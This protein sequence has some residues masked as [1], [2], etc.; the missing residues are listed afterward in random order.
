MAEPNP[1]DCMSGP[2]SEADV[3]AAANVERDLPTFQ[4]NVL[5]KYFRRANFSAEDVAEIDYQR[6]VRFPGVG[7][8]GIQNIRTWLHTFA[9]D[10]SNAPAPGDDS[11]RHERDP[12][13]KAQRIE[14]AIALLRKQ[15]FVVRPSR[16]PTESR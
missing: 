7:A 13:G 10:L 3:I 16:S 4:R 12:Q 15:G 14:R 2:S 11:T 6:L 8:K 5:R 9:L 1:S